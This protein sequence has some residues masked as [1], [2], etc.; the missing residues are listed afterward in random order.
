L[1]ALILAAGTG[2]RILP[3]TKVVPKALLPIANRPL[4]EY[5]IGQLE[6]AGLK[7]IV[8]V[9][10]YMGQRIKEFMENSEAYLDLDISYVEAERYMKGPIFSLLAAE[11][12]IEGEFLL[13][14]VDLITTGQIVTNMLTN[15]SEED[16]V[17]IAVD[18]K[19]SGSRGTSVSYSQ[20][21]KRNL[22]SIVALDSYVIQKDYNVK[23][24]VFLG[25]SIGMAILPREIF[26]CARSAARN[27]STKV[28]DA[29]N[30]FISQN[31]KG[32]CMM[33]GAEDHWFDVDTIETA[34]TA[35]E[36]VLERSLLGYKPNGKLYT[37]EFTYWPE[38]APTDPHLSLAGIIGPSIIGDES[39]IGSGSKIGPHV[40]I[41]KDCH[42]GRDVR[43]SNSIIVDG[44]RID[45]S[46]SI[47]AAIVY[48]RKILSARKIKNVI[49]GRD[50][51]NE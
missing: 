29:M 20:L 22:S 48:G 31:G 14:P 49:S 18:K 32:R 19:V 43:C 12:S 7:E 13:T 46:A 39:E 4:L 33:I 50:G 34:L 36:F 6:R 9:T 26:K 30:Q 8:I 45:D 51:E 3:L 42:I 24:N 40:S 44:S 11:K 47:D 27:G 35:N 28:V 41:Q 2:A 15:R 5:A 21:P 23:T 1:Q 17:Y 25:A 37:N 16:A 10:G 38:N